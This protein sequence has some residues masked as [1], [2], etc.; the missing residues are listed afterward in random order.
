MWP[1]VAPFPLANHSI[2]GYIP[3]GFTGWPRWR[4][5]TGGWGDD[6]A[7]QRSVV[8]AGLSIAIVLGLGVF[9]LL[10]REPQE[11]PGQEGSTGVP[12]VSCPPGDSVVMGGTGLL[13]TD[14]DGTPPAEMKKHL[15]ARAALESF[16]GR[17]FLTGSPLIS[18]PAA[19]EQVLDA[20]ALARFVRDIG[21]QRL[22]VVET[23][24][25]SG[26]GWLLGSVEL[27]N[28]LIRPHDAGREP[29]CAPRHRVRSSEGSI[30][31]PGCID[32]P[33]SGTWV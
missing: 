19:Y 31:E 13:A 27:C 6:V 9:R 30:P 18:N 3:L 2:T 25:V 20:P 28:S 1:K 32:G 17:P 22:A 33:A 26:C 21:G 16:V 24:S 7:D 12:T 14:E 15:S 10:A 23:R 5:G 8:L 11:E 4:P 29:S